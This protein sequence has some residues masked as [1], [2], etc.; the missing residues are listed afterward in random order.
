MVRVKHLVI[1]VKVNG[2]VKIL[3]K[4]NAPMCLFMS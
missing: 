4:I 1:I 2:S 3:P